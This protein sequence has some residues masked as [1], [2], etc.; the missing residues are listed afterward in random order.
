MTR[1]TFKEVLDELGLMAE[2]MGRAPH[3]WG[4]RPLTVSTAFAV[5]FEGGN[6]EH[7]A[8]ILPGGFVMFGDADHSEIIL[9]KKH[10]YGEWFA[11][12]PGQWPSVEDL[13]AM[14]V[15]LDG[16]PLPSWVR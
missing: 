6:F 16:G 4:V 8:R 7:V 11:R 5:E 12:L 15:W 13:H 10:P 14:R 1:S 9:R 2:V 3:D